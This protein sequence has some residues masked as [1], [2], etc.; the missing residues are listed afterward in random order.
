VVDQIRP[1]GCAGT[2]VPSNIQWQTAAEAKVKDKW[3]SA[4][5][6]E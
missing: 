6:D 1:L 3:E 5:A 2:D 4:A